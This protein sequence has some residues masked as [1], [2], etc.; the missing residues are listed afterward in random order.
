MVWVWFGMVCPMNGDLQCN[1]KSG[2]LGTGREWAA[3][4]MAN[5]TSNWQLNFRIKLPWSRISEHEEKGN[6]KWNATAN[7]TQRTSGTPPRNNGPSQIFRSIKN[8]CPNFALFVPQ[9]SFQSLRVTNRQWRKEILLLLR[10]TKREMI[11]M[12]YQRKRR[13]KKVK[14]IFAFFQP[15]CAE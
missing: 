8:I 10:S 3:T 14:I 1:H 2:A 7:T 4:D 15:K 13:E 9:H 11:I 6:E 12:K 5:K